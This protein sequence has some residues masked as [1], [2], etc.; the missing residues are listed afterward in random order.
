MKLEKR[1]GI[2]V[3]SMKK[4]ALDVSKNPKNDAIMNEARGIHEVTN[5]AHG[6]SNIR[7]SDYEIN[8][9]GNQLTVTSNIQ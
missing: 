3:R 4:Y 5:N 7:A 9:T 6:M 2:V 8:Q 1:L